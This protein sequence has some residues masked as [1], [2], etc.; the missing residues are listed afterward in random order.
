MKLFYEEAEL[1]IVL[2][3]VEDIITT[4]A[5][6]PTN[7]IATEDDMDEIT[8]TTG[9]ADPDDDDLPAEDT[10][11][12]TPDGGN[13]SG[14]D[15]IVPDTTNA[16]AVD[17][18]EDEIPADPVPDDPTGAPETTAPDD[19]TAAT[20]LPH[21]SDAGSAGWGDGDRIDFSDL[22]G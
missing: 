22:L 3:D 6:V 7:T 20:T 15:D 1:D 12:N 4:S 18:G 19:V 5:D 9:S 2:F 17:P 10:G 8:D 16:P 21:M 11:S 13:D 14:S